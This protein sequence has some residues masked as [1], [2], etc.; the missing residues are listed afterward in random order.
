[1]SVALEVTRLR[2]KKHW[3]FAGDK[4]NVSGYASVVCGDPDGGSPTHGNFPADGASLHR[5]RIFRDYL[6]ATL[7]NLWLGIV[8]PLAWPPLSPDI[9]H[10]DFFLWD[11]VKDKVYAT[12]VTGAEDP[13]T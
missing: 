1:M 10:L 12:K 9:T 3:V 5:C 2:R 8:G 13:K 6:D 4:G 7:P 11:Y